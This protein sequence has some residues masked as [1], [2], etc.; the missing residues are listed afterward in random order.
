MKGL[1]KLTFGF[2]DAENY[3]RRENKDLFE[4]IF[5]RTEALDQLKTSSTFFLVGEKGTGKQHMLF[6]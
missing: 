3:R 1:N 5:L 2:T 4:Q 6:T